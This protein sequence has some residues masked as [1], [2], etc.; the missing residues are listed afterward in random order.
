MC[1]Q[2]GWFEI[3]V[4]SKYVGV[5]SEFVDSKAQ[6]WKRGLNGVD[7]RVTFNFEDREDSRIFEDIYCSIIELSCHLST[8]FNTIAFLSLAS[9]FFKY[10]FKF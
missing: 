9:S 8:I 1:R 3:C 5:Q 6:V 10:D 4:K 2:A 7:S